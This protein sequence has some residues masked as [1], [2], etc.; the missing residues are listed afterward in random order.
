MTCLCESRSSKVDE[1]AASNMS[2][3]RLLWDSIGSLVGWIDGRIGAKTVSANSFAAHL[4]YGRIPKPPRRIGRLIRAS[5][6]AR[7]TSSREGP[8]DR[9]WCT[10]FRSRESRRSHKT[11]RS[12][13]RR[14]RWR[15]RRFCCTEMRRRSKACCFGRLG[16]RSMSF[17]SSLM[18]SSRG[19][20][21]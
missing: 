2:W 4:A 3:H 18:C 19:R 15:W 21:A 12:V 1:W 10:Q 8:R 5:P 14:D 17:R 11:V 16:S 6:M 9:I 13:E 7:C 20:R